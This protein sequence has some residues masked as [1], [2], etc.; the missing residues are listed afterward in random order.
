M[1]RSRLSKRLVR[2][3]LKIVREGRQVSI[4]T[5]KTVESEKS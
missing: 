1:V 2:G 4:R 5:M 3:R